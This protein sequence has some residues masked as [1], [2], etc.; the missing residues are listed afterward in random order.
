MARNAHTKCPALAAP[1]L[2]LLLALT[3]GGPCRNSASANNADDANKPAAAESGARANVVA[4][5]AKGGDTNTGGKV[6]L[7]ANRSI[8]TGG[9]VVP[10]G[11]WGGE[12]VRLTVRSGGADI[13]FD[14]AHGRMAKLTTDAAGNFSAEGVFVA[15]RGGPVRPG[16]REDARPARYSGRV[17]GKRMTLSITVSGADGE[18]EPVVYK[19]TRGAEAELTKCL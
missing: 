9:G 7:S 17:E 5:A 3:Q 13:E 16:D 12:H 10:T 8:E 2:L 6:N 11:T 18:A 14:C 1:L 4:A 15:E 19:L